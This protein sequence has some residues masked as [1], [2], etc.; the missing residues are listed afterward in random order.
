MVIGGFLK[1]YHITYKGNS[2]S[3]QKLFLI[4]INMIFLTSPK[5]IVT[6][7]QSELEVNEDLLDLNYCKCHCDSCKFNCKYRRYLTTTIFIGILI[8]PLWLINI[9]M[10]LY[11]CFWLKHDEIRYD[12]YI[13]S[14]DPKFASRNIVNI[15]PLNFNDEIC[16]AIIA[17]HESLRSKTIN[18]AMYSLGCLIVYGIFVGLI[19]YGLLHPPASVH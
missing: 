17:H 16:E 13:H 10:I 1:L 4:I 18:L 3:T 15:P 12:E 14:H 8:P 2:L 11:S 9:V 6:I 19:V 5:P 7:G